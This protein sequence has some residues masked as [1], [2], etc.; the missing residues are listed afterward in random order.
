MIRAHRWASVEAQREQLERDGC[1]AIIELGKTPR[2]HIF[3]WVRE[4]SVV[5]VLFAFLLARPGKGVH[6]LADYRKFAERLT[7]LPD[8]RRAAVKDVD[9]GLVADTASARRAMLLIV[10]QQIARHKKGARSAA[11]LPRGGQPLAFSEADMLKAEAIWRNPKKYP[12]WQAAERAMPKGFTRWRAHALWG[13][14]R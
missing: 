12:T 13:A 11:N 10:K 5:K 2:E 1:R 3:R 4:R 8:G 9:S 7:T 14:R 6:M